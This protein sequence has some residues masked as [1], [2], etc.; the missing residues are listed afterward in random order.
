MMRTSVVKI[1]RLIIVLLAL[2]SVLL[3][4]PGL[5]V[6]PAEGSEG[7]EATI[8][9]YQQLAPATVYLSS[10]YVSGDP[11]GAPP[12]MGVG[13][14]FILDEAGTVLTNAHVVEGARLI[15][16]TLYNGQRVKAEL[17]GID[18]YTDLAVVRLTHITGKLITARLGDS[19]R[20][21]IG[22]Q[23]L[24][25]G[26]PF[27]LGFTLTSGIVSGM[28]SLPGAV[29]PSESS[30]IQTT[31]P[32][33]PGNSGGP[34][35]DSEGRVIGITTAI[36]AGAQNIGFAIPINTAKAVLSELKEK[37]RVARPW[38]GVGGKFTTNEIRLLL[39]WPLAPG[40]LVEHVEEGSPAAEAGLRAGTLHVAIE[41]MPWMIGGDIIVSIQGKSIRSPEEFLKAINTLRVGETVKIEFLRDG[42]RHQRSLV[43]RPRPISLPKTTAS[44]ETRTTGTL[45]GGP[46]GIAQICC[47]R[48]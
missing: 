3:W 7:E 42:E 22:Q 11:L 19:D 46:I 21:R 45:P 41:G 33:N 23:V 29:K 5:T 16:A 34:M 8:R 14:G 25:L 36:L 15:M 1:R 13:A 48:Y 2:G 26:S 9:L 27:G 35:V 32:I 18:P 39:K 37:G 38:L 4:R 31:A 28:A 30:V 40:L 6:S 20:V 43:L 17:I 24:V 44:P 47:I 10:A 12:A